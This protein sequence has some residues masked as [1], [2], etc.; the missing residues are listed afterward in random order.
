MKPVK[1]NSDREDV[2]IFYVSGANVE[3]N[4]MQ[5]TEKLFQIILLSRSS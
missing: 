1:F 2:V 3:P 5:T 4:T